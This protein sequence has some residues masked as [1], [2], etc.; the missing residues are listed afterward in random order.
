MI[1]GGQGAIVIGTNMEVGDGG[2]DGTK[3]TSCS[4][5]LTSS[6]D[7]SRCASSDSLS[8]EVEEGTRILRTCFF[9]CFRIGDEGAGSDESPYS[10]RF[11]EGRFRVERPFF[12]FFSLPLFLTLSASSRFCCISRVR[13]LG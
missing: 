6:S 2:G 3:F 9:T 11:F 12:V 10:F 4:F 5:L 13:I 8:D 7:S 1:G